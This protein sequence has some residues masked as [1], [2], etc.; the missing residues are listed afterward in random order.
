MPFRREGIV[1]RTGKGAGEKFRVEDPQGE[2]PSVMVMF[3]IL[4]LWL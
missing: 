1:Q 3:L 2:L 4:F